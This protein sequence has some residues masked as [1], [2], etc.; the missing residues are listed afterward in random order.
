MKQGTRKVLLWWSDD[1]S[2]WQSRNGNPSHRK[3]NTS[4]ADRESGYSVKT[5]RVV[6]PTEI[7]TRVLRTIAEI[8]VGDGPA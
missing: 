3:S 5:E 2:W 8:D 6:L 1:I 4:K 7:D